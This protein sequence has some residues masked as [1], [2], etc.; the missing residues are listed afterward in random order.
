VRIHAVASLAVVCLVVVGCGREP[1]SARRSPG[2]PPRLV[3]LGVDG[4]DW[5]IIDPLVESGRMPVMERLLA[6]GTRADLL[7]LVP[8]EKSPV[9][10]TTIATGRLPE[11]QGRGF[12]IDS[13]PD[14]AKAYTA[15]NRSTRAFWNILPDLGF[16]VSVLGW[17]ETWP[18]ERVDGT[19]VSDYVQYDVAERGKARRFRHR[20]FPEELFEVVEP[21]VVYPRDVTDADL[22]R[23]I[24]EL[25]SG[26]LPRVI[27]T[28]LGDLR[29]ILAG[30][31]TFTALAEDFL[32][33]RREDVMAIY[34]RGPDA[35]C[36]KFWGAREAPETAGEESD[37]TAV[38]R[39]TVDRYFEATDELIGRILAHIDL[40]KTSVLL[41]SDHGF[42]GGSRALDG[43]SRL[44]VWMHR[45]LG[46]VLL[47]G[48]AAAGP[49]L[50][51]EGARVVDVFPTVLH[52][53]GQPVA[54][55][56]DGEPARW[57]LAP[58]MGRDREPGGIATYET[59]ER[60]EIPTD[61]ESLVD[62]QI[63]ERVEA[64]GYIE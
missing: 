10:W 41:V 34:L 12:L 31:L 60:P 11:Q 5:E 30:D 29:W 39:G 8:L 49:G 21:L 54:A 44:G 53:L 48:P 56:L 24:G 9:I 14:S 51:V 15:W 62:E 17:L 4:F 35:A 32:A 46:T 63:R 50:R 38:F 42:Q 1:S 19:I 28:G 20:T 36:H 26:E 47:V 33:N 37:F 55:D 57:L 52:L 25:P 18:A 6:R 13:G 40:E 7:T 2:D 61:A 23:L 27:R 3:I 64:L 16:T 58:E 43:S 59:G 22:A 45:E